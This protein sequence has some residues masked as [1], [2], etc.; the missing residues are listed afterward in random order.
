MAGFNLPQEPTAR[1]TKLPAAPF[2]SDP[3]KT[4]FDASKL[5][6]TSMGQPISPEV[7]PSNWSITEDGEGGIIAKCSQTGSEFTGSHS[8]FNALLKELRS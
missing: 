5:R 1:D 7:N 8:E 6:A 3:M 4:N 2:K